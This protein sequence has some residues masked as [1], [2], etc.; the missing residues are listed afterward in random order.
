VDNAL[1]EKD[2]RFAADVLDVLARLGCG[3]FL[4]GDDR[5]VISKNPLATALLRDG[6]VVNAGFR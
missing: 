1:E 6:L 3:C 2:T 4:L 5:R